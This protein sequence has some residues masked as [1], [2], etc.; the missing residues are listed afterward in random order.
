MTAFLPEFIPSILLYYIIY[1]LQKWKGIR[2]LEILIKVENVNKSIQKHK[3]WIFWKQNGDCFSLVQMVYSL[4]NYLAGIMVWIPYQ[5]L[6]LVSRYLKQILHVHWPFAFTWWT[7][8][9]CNKMAY[10]IFIKL[11]HCNWFW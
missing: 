6:C 7:I 9:T 11:D 10:W 5:Y 1:D 3:I 4:L 8:C 2:V